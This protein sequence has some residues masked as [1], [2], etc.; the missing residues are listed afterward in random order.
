MVDGK[1]EDGCIVRIGIDGRLWTQS[2]VGRYIRNL[3]SNLEGIDKK[4]EYFIFLLK[5][6]FDQL[7]FQK[8]FTKVLVD[9][10]WYGIKEQIKFPS[11]LK[12]YNLDLVHFPHFNIPIFYKDKF[13]VTIHD[14]IHQ[15]FQMR[16]A[17][18]RDP[19]IYKIKQLGYKTVFKNAINKSSHILVPSDY[20]KDLL[21]K[22]WNVIS[23]V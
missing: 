5:K 9:F 4:N 21:E 12:K 20:V 13:I 11:L 14:L 3:V 8:N 10:S 22:E 15:H 18:T 2:G 1:K 23:L 17:T 7:K 16:R 19:I 6:E